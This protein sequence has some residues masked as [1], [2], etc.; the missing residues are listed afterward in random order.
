MAIIYSY[1]Q[2][3]SALKN[4]RLIITR[5]DEEENEITTK[6]LTLGQIADY[7]VESSPVVTGTGTPN[8]LP[9][10]G[11]DGGSIVDSHLLDDPYLGLSRMT[12][13]N[14]EYFSINQNTANNS[15]GTLSYDIKQDN[16]TKAQ[17][18][19]TDVNDGFCFLYNRAGNGWRIGASSDYPELTI[20]TTSGSE[21]VEIANN[22]TVG[23]NATITGTLNTG[24]VEVSN[25]IEANQV[26]VEGANRPLVLTKETTIDA[27]IA[28]VTTGE[29]D[30]FIA[31]KN[32]HIVIGG[33]NGYSTDNL[34][35]S[36]I[37]GYV[38]IK[39]KAPLAPLHVKNNG[40]AIRLESTGDNVCSIDF[41]QGTDKR[42]HIQFENE[43]NTLDIRTENPTGATSKIK[44]SVAENGQPAEEV[45]RIQHTP[46]V[47]YKQVVIGNP[48]KALSG[49][50]LYVK[51]DI[52]T[53]NVLRG[54]EVSITG[55]CDADSYKLK[56]LNSAPATATSP[57]TFGEIRYTA[58]YIYVCVQ[59]DVWKR[60]AL[61]T[62]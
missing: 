15:A 28:M 21:G 54:R 34:N 41:R 53:T 49:A 59:N 5:I 16:Y 24:I 61:T 1:P 60:V 37:N 30:G 6:Q 32:D 42:G 10:W 17:F 56:G 55:K 11:A 36:K 12:L 43:N 35:I 50:A 39:Q 38:G 48:E 2:G 27:H 20:T 52:E 25:R 14:A 46:T 3:S 9:I 62:W 45:M 40:E 7:I 51:G 18:G 8:Y 13:E 23:A 47:G 58:D 33:T 57:G 26:R 22:L 29:L 19:F 4:D 31:S 44:F